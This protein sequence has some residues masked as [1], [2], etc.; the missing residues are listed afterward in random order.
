[1]ALVQRLAEE[2]ADWRIRYASVVDQPRRRAAFFAEG[3]ER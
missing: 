3:P 1:M 2:A